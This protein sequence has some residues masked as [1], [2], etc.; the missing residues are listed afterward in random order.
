[1][2][3][4]SSITLFSSLLIACAACNTKSFRDL[5]PTGE[6][7]VYES[8]YDEVYSN[9][10]TA[11]TE[12]QLEVKYH[13]PASG[14]IYASGRI[15]VGLND[16]GHPMLFGVFLRP[17]SPRKTMVEVQETF[18]YGYDPFN[19]CPCF[20]PSILQRLDAMLTGSPRGDK[21][22]EMIRDL[23]EQLADGLK[24]HRIQSLAVLP[25]TPVSGGQATPL[26][27]YLAERLAIEMYKTGV[28][29]VVERALLDKVLEE[30]R[31]TMSPRFDDASVKR[32]G[33]LLGV[34]SIVIGS[35]AE[36][37]KQEVEI[38]TRAVH[39]ETGEIMAVGNSSIRRVPV[40][41]VHE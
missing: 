22:G 13:N 30:M 4:V 16:Q 39:V 10:L 18:A 8:A 31:L 2:Q 19:L 11:L 23:T 7:K 3:F 40:E 24:S 5:Q 28:S 27:T 38:N 34:E 33:H 12:S 20:A 29:K 36:G 15:R 32:I 1:M 9:T 25:M 14:T 26:G 37:A 21:I 41:E 17:V 35:Y 6:G